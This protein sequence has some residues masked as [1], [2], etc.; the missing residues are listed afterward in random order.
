MTHFATFFKCFKRPYL[1]PFESNN[2]RKNE[3]FI[4]TV[5]DALSLILW[6]LS[7]VGLVIPF[8]DEVTKYQS[9]ERNIH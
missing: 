1:C 3:I 9:D 2:N 7:K 4:G 5:L 8:S 6:Y